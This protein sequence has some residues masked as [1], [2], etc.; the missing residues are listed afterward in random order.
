MTWTNLDTHRVTPVQ[1]VRIKIPPRHLGLTLAE[2]SH[3]DDGH[4]QTAAAAGQTPTAEQSGR[5]AQ[6]L[7]ALSAA[8][9]VC[10]SCATSTTSPPGGAES[11]GTGSTV[12]VPHTVQHHDNRH[13]QAGEMRHRHRGRCRD[14][15]P[16]AGC[17]A[18]A[19]LR[20]L[21]RRLQVSSAFR[22]LLRVPSLPTSHQVAQGRA[23]EHRR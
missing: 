21:R 22:A 17:S 4:Q 11:A 18:S 2:T 10:G 5:A 13:Q 23:P 9:P 6:L 7:P 15:S 12:V 16:L 1:I 19:G 3:G 20:S 14:S 8:P